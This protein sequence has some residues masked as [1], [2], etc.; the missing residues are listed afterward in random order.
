MDEAKK[1]LLSE[2]ASEAQK[3]RF[4]ELR[5]RL[6]ITEPASIVG[7]RAPAETSFEE[8]E[9]YQFLKQLLGYS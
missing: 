1:K 3:K 9:E 6:G 4:D 7:G 2:M 8:H 5:Q